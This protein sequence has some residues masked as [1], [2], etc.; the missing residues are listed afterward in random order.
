MYIYTRSA[1]ISVSPKLGNQMNLEDLTE[2]QLE[3]AEFD[4]LHSA[5]SC[6]FWGWPCP[7]SAGTADMLLTELG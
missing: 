4:A 7:T 6:Y 3:K 1:A 2:G 5:A